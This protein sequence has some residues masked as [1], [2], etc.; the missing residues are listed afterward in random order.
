M[1][2]VFLTRLI[3]ITQVINRYKSEFPR[4]RGRI[5]TANGRALFIRTSREMIPIYG[6]S[7]VDAESHEPPRARCMKSPQVPYTLAGLPKLVLLGRP[8]RTN[9]SHIPGLTRT[10]ICPKS[11]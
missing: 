7:Q 11:P 8:L 6:N 5:Q 2:T 9:V 3:W 4:I 1:L 10:P